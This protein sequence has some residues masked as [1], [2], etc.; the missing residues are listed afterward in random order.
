M[1]ERVNAVDGGGNPGDEK[2][3]EEEEGDAGVEPG[4][5][6]GFR[7]G[8]IARESAHAEEFRSHGVGGFAPVVIVGFG[9]GADFHVDGVGVETG[10]VGG[11][12]A[13]EAGDAHF[14]VF[15]VERVLG[16]GGGGARLPG[17]RLYGYLGGY[18]AEG[19]FV[20]GV[21]EGAEGAS[22]APDFAEGEAVDCEGGDEGDPIEG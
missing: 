16:G 22:I 11:V 19:V 18:G 7:E 2:G 15:V 5:G 20:E 10:V 8:V 3:A 9:V 6:V 1:C 21:E 4:V 14:F 13:F 17:F 12:V